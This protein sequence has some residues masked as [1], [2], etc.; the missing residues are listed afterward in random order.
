MKLFKSF[1]FKVAF[2][3]IILLVFVIVARLKER[4]K[5]TLMIPKN[6]G[7][8]EL[9]TR[10]DQ[11]CAAEVGGG[12]YIFDWNHLQAGYRTLESDNEPALVLDDNR[13]LSVKDRKGLILE[14]TMKKPVWIPIPA[15]YTEVFL[16][17]D[18]SCR[19]I[20]LTQENNRGTEVE[21]RFYRVDLKQE[22]VLETATLRN[23]PDFVLRK[24]M[25]PDSQD[26]IA[27]AGSKENQAYLTVIDL[28]QGRN[29]WEKTYPEEGEIFTLCSRNDKDIVYAGCQNGSVIEI[30]TSSGQ[31][32]RRIVLV[33]EPRKS[34]QI[35][36]IQR[37]VLNPNQTVLVASCDPVIYF[38]DL[39]TFE[40]LK[41][42]N[43]PHKIISGMTFSPDG[44][45]L[46]TADLRASGS[47]RIHSLSEMSE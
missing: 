11:L 33:A 31:V 22:I 27:A 15:N 18:S 14:I 29:L 16:D 45:Y 21:Y 19:T 8:E 9:W 37:V 46:A 38:V 47:I 42:I 41:K 1:S 2:V 34:T 35:R 13:I 44:K 6:R 30:D 3:F 10:D 26:R 25:I 39:K 36:T 4:N 23:G 43:A 17:A 24:I 12:F 28:R 20:I 40:V 7:I 32:L 5:L